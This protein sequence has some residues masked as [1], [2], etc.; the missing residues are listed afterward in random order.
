MSR[1]MNRFET[2]V[3]GLGAMGSSAVHRLARRGHRVLGIDR[4]SPPHAY[5]SSH[6][7]TRI[8]RLAIGEGEQYTPLALRS[9]ELWRE[10]ERAT[11]MR[12]LTRTGGLIISSSAKSSRSHV[13]DFFE[14]TLAAARRY[15]IA[16]ELLDAVE[17]RRR[18]PPFKALDDEHGYLERDAGFLRPE[19][20][21]RAQLVLAQ[22]SGATIRRGETALGFDASDRGVTLRTDRGSF[23]ADR[24]IVAAGPWLPGLVGAKLARHFAVYRQVLFWFEIDGPAEA[25]RPEVCP[26]FIWELQG[27]KQGI[28]GFPAVDGPRGGMKIATEAYEGTTTPESVTREVSEEEK[29]AMYEEYAAPRISGVSRRCLKAAVCLYTVSPDFGFVIDAHPDSERV[30]IVSACSGHGFKHS[31]AVGEALAELVIDGASRLDLSPFS[32]ARLGAA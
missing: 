23:E 7:E 12:L 32:L 4:F 2:I 1:S 20:C 25:F 27:R 13:E 11:G 17:I 21:V 6:G 22:Q 29:K 5:G 26:V 31:P 30:L 28:Y 15:G 24:L 16:H 19:E 10:M 3:L 8:T 14:N 18:F 9:H